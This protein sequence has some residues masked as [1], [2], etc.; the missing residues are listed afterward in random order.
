MST[1]AIEIS[2][3]IPVELSEQQEHR[4]YDLISDI[5]R[6]NTPDGHVHWL[7][8]YGS[9]PQLSQ[10]DQRF[11]GKPVDPSA[12]QSG[13]PTFDDSVLYFETYCREQ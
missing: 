6:A 10:A 1:T 9:K 12:P 5:A 7:S 2:F 11:M 8:S 4:L 13:E 3:A